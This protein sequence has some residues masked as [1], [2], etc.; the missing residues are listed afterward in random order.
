[1]GKIKYEYAI[2]IWTPAGRDLLQP[3]DIG[4]TFHIITG[5]KIC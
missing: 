2:L 3:L 4:G 1:M 5:L